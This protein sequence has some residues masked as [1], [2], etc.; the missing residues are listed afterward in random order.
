MVN[1]NI[2]SGSLI[3]FPCWNF[4]SQTFPGPA[5]SNFLL[6]WF[7]QRFQAKIFIKVQLKLSQ[8]RLIS[9]FSESLTLNNRSSTGNCLCNKLLSFCFEF[10]SPLLECVSKYFELWK[11][12][13]FGSWRENKKRKS[14]ERNY[15]TFIS[16][17]LHPLNYSHDSSAS[18][19][20][21]NASLAE[22]ISHFYFG[23]HN[24]R[25]WHSL[26]LM[27]LRRRHWRR[28][29]H[30][31]FD[32][33]LKY[34]RRTKVKTVSAQGECRRWKSLRRSKT[35]TTTTT[36]IM[37]SSAIF[38]ENFSSTKG[39]LM[40]KYFDLVPSAISRQVFPSLSAY[41]HNVIA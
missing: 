25:C 1:R 36:M 4:Q 8:F 19:T 30:Q 2:A 20:K 26:A 34:C 6:C 14:H 7:H 24:S 28:L 17:F 16:R 40:N 12:A 31:S 23:D 39:I 10:S 38:N 29:A 3:I 18:D 32:P 21:E 37:T 33:A 5:S 27:W 9:I 13:D 15:L 22:V 11:F 35:T 41:Q